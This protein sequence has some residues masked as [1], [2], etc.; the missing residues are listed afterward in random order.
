MYRNYK[1]LDKVL[2]G[3]NSFNQVEE[4][5]SPLRVSSGNY[6]LFLVDHYFEDKK[7]VDRL[8]LKKGDIIKY[9][10][11]TDEPATYVVDSIV[12]EIKT[13]RA[14][15]PVSVVGIG[16]GSVMDYA[17]AVRLMFT[18]E[19]SSEQYQGLGLVKNKGVHCVVV[20]TIS[21]TGAEISMTAVLTGP[22]K[23]LG[24]KGDFTTPDQLIMDP[25]FNKTVPR[26]QRFFTAMDCYIH[27]VEAINGGKRTI[28]GN[29]FGQESLRLC[30]DIF[31]TDGT[32]SDENDE[33]LMVA[34]YLGGLSLTYS[35]VGACHAMS[36]G[37]ATVT[38]IHHGVGNCVVF[39]QL[40]EFY[41]VGVEEFHLMAEKAGV[42]IPTGITANC[43]EADI[44]KMVDV[45]L[46]L[47]FMWEHCAGKDWEKVITRDKLRKLYM[48]M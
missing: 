36:Y 26:D 15:N 47:T 17:K 5:L 14:E 1:G 43:N 29:S 46:S 44:E 3:Y 7:L 41:P 10:D 45:A 35:E 31:L 48:K 27:N 40:E 11:V 4:V 19:G 30:K 32:R 9:M 42:K 34:S 28:L 33:K 6:I 12:A 8:P 13:E 18:N 20:P 2:Y 38:H 16:G 24:L 39:K 21:G 22:E 37:L 25:S 23:K